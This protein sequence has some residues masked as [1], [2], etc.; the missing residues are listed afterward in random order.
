MHMYFGQVCVPENWCLWKNYQYKRWWF[1]FRVWKVW[2]VGQFFWVVLHQYVANACIS[3]E[4]V[5]IPGYGNSWNFVKP[6]K[7]KMLKYAFIFLFILSLHF[8]GCSVLA[9]FSRAYI[10]ISFFLHHNFVI[11]RVPKHFVKEVHLQGA[12]RLSNFILCWPLS[13]L[14]SILSGIEVMSLS[15]SHL[16]CSFFFSP[17]WM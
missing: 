12:F 6:L 17:Y 14:V 15:F 4:G 9:S 10:N 5:L 1:S 7:M 11:N 13:S 2:I 3:N 16:W 8:P